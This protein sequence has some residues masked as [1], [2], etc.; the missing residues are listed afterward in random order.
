MLTDFFTDIFGLPAEERKLAHDQRQHWITL[1][2][3]MNVDNGTP[4]V[5]RAKLDKALGKLKNNKGSPDGVSAEIL[6]ALP[7][8]CNT[9]L[10]RTSPEDVRHWGFPSLGV[11]R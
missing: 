3:D 11:L 5:T 8:E 7:E 9:S 4:F 6:Q 10:L 1:A 2:K